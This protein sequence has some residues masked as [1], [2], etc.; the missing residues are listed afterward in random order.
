L[1]GK[2]V[3]PERREQLQQAKNELVTVPDII[4]QETLRRHQQLRRFLFYFLTTYTDTSLFFEQVVQQVAPFLNEENQEWLEELIAQGQ[5]IITEA[6]VIARKILH[7]QEK[8]P[9]I[10]TYQPDHNG[11]FFEAGSLP[12]LPTTSTT[13]AK[14]QQRFSKCLALLREWYQDLITFLSAQK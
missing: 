5:E 14:D 4:Y 1:N 2:Y 10:D 6:L 11:I 7:E 12:L 8:I 3:I 9:T 13:S